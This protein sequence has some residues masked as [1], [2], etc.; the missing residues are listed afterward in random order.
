MKRVEKESYVS[1]EGTI[2]VL[3]TQLCLLTTSFSGTGVLGDPEEGGEFGID[4]DD[5]ILGEF[6]DGGEF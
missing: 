6:G 4:G 3:R 5:P 1:P 2:F